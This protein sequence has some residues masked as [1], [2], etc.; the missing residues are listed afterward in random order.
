MVFHGT[1]LLSRMTMDPIWKFK[2][3]REKLAD[4]LM[5]DVFAA[6]YKDKKV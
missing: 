4:C 1:E 2:M 6:I 5:D 3:S